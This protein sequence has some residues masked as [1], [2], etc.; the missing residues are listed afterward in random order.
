MAK[1]QKP[2]GEEPKLCENCGSIMIEDDEG[3]LYCPNCDAEIDWGMEDEEDE[4]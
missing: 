1:K 2:A 4:E 3:K